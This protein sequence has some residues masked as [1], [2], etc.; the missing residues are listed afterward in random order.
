MGALFFVCAVASA[1]VPVVGT[2]QRGGPI[3]L[4]VTGYLIG[5]AG[6]AVLLGRRFAFSLPWRVRTRRQRLV[7][8]L[9]WVGDIVTT[10]VACA[11]LGNE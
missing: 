11:E 3:D 4:L 9:V 7:A 6:L 8:A 5:A 10:L 2:G 1:V